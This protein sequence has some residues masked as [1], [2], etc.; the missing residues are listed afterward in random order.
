MKMAEHKFQLARQQHGQRHDRSISER[1]RYDGILMLSPCGS[2]YISFLNPDNGICQLEV[3]FQN[4]DILL[5]LLFSKNFQFGHLNIAIT[6]R[7]VTNIHTKWKPTP[8]WAL[9]V[10]YTSNEVRPGS[11][12]GL[13]FKLIDRISYYI[14]YHIL[15][16]INFMGHS[17]ITALMCI[18]VAQVYRGRFST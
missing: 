17:W 12:S 6:S 16:S 18:N 2:F 10:G 15:Y 4:N 3:T 8:S 14:L 5:F 1:Y 9:A 7:P 13:I 11:T